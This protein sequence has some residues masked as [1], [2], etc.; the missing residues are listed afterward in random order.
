ML[1]GQSLKLDRI[2]LHLLFSFH[3][4]ELLDVLWLKDIKY[5][6]DFVKEA[7]DLRRLTTLGSL[8]SQSIRR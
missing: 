5:I 2:D 6:Q 7:P 4:V 1:G 8:A 3:I